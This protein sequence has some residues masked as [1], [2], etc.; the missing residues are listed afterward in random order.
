MRPAEFRIQCPRNLAE[1]IRLLHQAEPG[2]AVLAGGQA[3][4]K[5]LRE[6]TIAPTVLLDISRLAELAYIERRTDS[7]E[8]GA[9]TTLAVITASKEV[10]ADCPAL[11]EAARRVGDV[12]IRTRATLGGNILSGWASD[13]AVVMTALD[14]RVELY[15]SAGSRSMSAGDLIVGG[16][17]ADELLRVVSVP[18]MPASAFEKLSRRSADPVIASAAATVSVAD[19]AHRHG[20]AVGGVHRH[21]A[22]LPTVEALLDSGE[23]DSC[24]ITAAVDAALAG[25]APPDTPHASAVF[26]RRVAPVMALRAITRARVIAGLGE[27]V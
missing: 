8:I 14:A 4:L 1:A 22:R 17:P 18:A 12:Q 5:Q 23:R 15:S 11:M 27:L 2:T 25:F 19:G 7:L 20:L 6:R 16:C 9:L 24:A 13:L 10:A 3:L 21:A 26:R